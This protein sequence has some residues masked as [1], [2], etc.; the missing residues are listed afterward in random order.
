VCEPAEAKSV[1][2]AAGDSVNTTAMEEDD[3]DDIPADAEECVR[4]Q[5]GG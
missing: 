4:Q 1:A 2:A 5:S 3:F